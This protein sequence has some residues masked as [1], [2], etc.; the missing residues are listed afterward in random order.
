[1][2]LALLLLPED[3]PATSGFGSRWCRDYCA[4]LRALPG[5]A[6]CS[7][8][9]GEAVEELR[10]GGRLA[11]T[12]LVAVSWEAARRAGA[13]PSMQLTL[14]SFSWATALVQAGAPPSLQ[15]KPHYYLRSPNHARAAQLD[16]FGQ[17]KG[18]PRGAGYA[19][20]SRFLNTVPLFEVRDERSCAALAALALPCL[21]STDAPFV[22]LRRMLRLPAAPQPPL[23]VVRSAPPHL[24][25]DAPAETDDSRLLALPREL[26]VRILALLPSVAVARAQLVCRL[27]AY[28]C[29]SQLPSRAP[30]RL[31]TFNL[32][33][34][35]INRFTGQPEGV[36]CRAWPQRCNVVAAALAALRPAVA[37]LQEDDADMMRDVFACASIAHLPYAIY[38]VR[39][40]GRIGSRTVLGEEAERDESA[41][42]LE[43][44]AWE[45]GSIMYDTEVLELVVGGGFAWRD[46]RAKKE[47][48]RAARRCG[49]GRTHMI[50]FT[51][52]LLRWRAS[53]PLTASAAAALR[54]GAPARP[55][56]GC[57]LVLNTHL[58][59]GHDWVVD[60]PARE[61]SMGL[62]REALSRLRSR[63]GPSVPFTLS[64][65]M[66]CQKV[67]GYYKRFLGHDAFDPSLASV[68]KLVDS[69]VALK[70]DC[71]HKQR[72]EDAFVKHRLGRPGDWVRTGGCNGTT[73][74]NFSGVPKSAATS[75]AMGK[76]VQHAA[77]ADTRLHADGHECHIDHVLLPEAASMRGAVRV[78]TAWVETTACRAQAS[79][80]TGFPLEGSEE[81]CCGRGPSFRG[82]GS[83][84]S[85]H[86]PVV[87]DLTFH[88][89]R[90]CSDELRSF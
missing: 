63:F 23:P 65:D 35:G 12:H 76:Q 25:Y 61:R 29:S 38:P 46:G 72:A 84:A 3:G 39:I 10:A 59:A 62:I 68:E 43:R 88:W 55:P 18:G 22:T 75:E 81:W 77:A 83:W 45:Q 33:N 60:V 14:V 1:M 74:H 47:A 2:S 41:A 8:L 71:P 78:A 20:A 24:R 5:L 19:C 66:N 40:E 36:G 26:L 53:A 31:V 17:R 79:A 7:V 73:W 21:R 30:L 69:F 34:N 48:E 9:E 86:F 85:D 82:K 70:H 90:D 50:P 67:Q 49:L 11:A 32:K 56:P 54:S 57:L 28:L 6:T 89:T 37:C 44:P 16:K 51:W 4:R 64:G 13:Q 80:C 87:V 52:A 27:F 58:E 15:A 42:G